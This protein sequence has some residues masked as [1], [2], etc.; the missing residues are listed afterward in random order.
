MFL[1]LLETFEGDLS[2]SS[3]EIHSFDFDF[4]VEEEFLKLLETFEG[5]LSHCTDEVH[6]FDFDVWVEEEFFETFE[7]CF[8][9]YWQYTFLSGDWVIESKTFRNFLYKVITFK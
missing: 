5:D 2:H 1:K 3:N 8:T 9:N 4:W 6:S 7:F